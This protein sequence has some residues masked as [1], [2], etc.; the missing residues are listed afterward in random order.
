MYCIYHLRKLKVLDGIGVDAQELALARDTFSGKLTVEFLVEKLGHK[1]FAHIRELDL[2]SCRIR[3]V[4][5]IRS[6]PS[7]PLPLRSALLCSAQRVNAHEHCPIAN[8]VG[9]LRFSRRAA[10]GVCAGTSRA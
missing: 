4:Q 9:S 1:R 10:G 8:P 3:S 7:A 5:G 2:S 6:D